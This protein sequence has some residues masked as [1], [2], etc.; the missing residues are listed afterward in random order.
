M[1]NPAK[2]ALPLMTTRLA[3]FAAPGLLAILTATT[4]AAAPP[5]PRTPASQPSCSSP[6]SSDLRVPSSQR[7]EQVD[8]PVS[9][10]ADPQQPTN[11]QPGTIV[12]SDGTSIPGW[13][14]TTQ[15]QPLRLYVPASRRY[16]QIPLRQ[17]VRI[18]AIVQ[19]QR[20]QPPWYWKEPANDEKILAGQAY[21]VRKTSYRI[22]LRDDSELVAD[23][24]QTLWLR[25]AD[26]HV[27]R[28]LLH[29]RQKAD[30]GTTLE[31]LLSVQE[32]LFDAD[33]SNRDADSAPTS[34]PATQPATA[35]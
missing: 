11:A 13:I 20:Q 31:D 8:L 1:G 24:A 6:R 7:T 4:L 27:R 19:W 15:D 21:P 23:V 17:V 29:K 26:G 2:T 33:G 10:F 28:F 9:P 14:S 25:Q 22:R 18:Q 35:R 5:S 3:R 12:L 30:P 16:V 34:R 32:V